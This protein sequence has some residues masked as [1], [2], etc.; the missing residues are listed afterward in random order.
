M[1]FFKLG[2]TIFGAVVTF[3]AMHH[4]FAEE[5]FT[6]DTSLLFTSFTAVIL[7]GVEQLASGFIS[8]ML[9]LTVGA[10]ESKSGASRGNPEAAKN[11]G[12][13]D[14]DDDDEDDGSDDDDSESDNDDDDRGGNEVWIPLSSLVALSKLRQ[15]PTGQGRPGVLASSLESHPPPPPILEQPQQ[16]PQRIVRFVGGK[17]EY[18]EHV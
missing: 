10:K 3:R 17:K 9:K 16:R 8:F 6:C 14:D 7:C 15:S 1:V 5:N 11:D 13:D 4:Y 12:D 18:L 2:W